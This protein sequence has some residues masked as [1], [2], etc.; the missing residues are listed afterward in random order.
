[1]NCYKGKVKSVLDAANRKLIRPNLGFI[2]YV[3]H[4][5]QSNSN[6][7]MIGQ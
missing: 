1:M 6:R 4:P 2:S 7:E 5:I 3:C